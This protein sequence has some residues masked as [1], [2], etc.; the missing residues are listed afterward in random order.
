MKKLFIAITLMIYSFLS[1][2][3]LFAATFTQADLTGTW[4]I[5]NLRTSDGIK[6]MRAL[7]TLNSSGV[8][9]CVSLSDSGGGTTC[10]SPFDLTFTMN[11]TTGVITQSWTNPAGDDGHMTMTLNKIMQKVVP[12][13]TYSATD[14]QSKSM[15]YHQLMVGDS[16]SWEYGAATT[17]GLALVNI[18]S[19]TTPSGTTTPEDTGCTIEVDTMGVVT[20]TGLSCDMG[21]FSGFLSSDKKTIVG[22]RTELSADTYQLFIFQITGQT[23]TAGTFPAGTAVAHTL[24][25]GAAAFWI[26]YTNTIDSNGVM[27][28]SDWVASNPAITAPAETYTGYIDALGTVTINGNPTFHGQ[29][30][31]DRTFTVGTQ[32]G[33]VGN[34]LYML[35]VSTKVTPADTN[36]YGHFTGAGIWKWDGSTWSQV[37][38]NAPTEMA[39]SGSILYGNFSPGGIWKWD[40]STWSQVTP[41]SPTAMA[42]SG[43][44]LYGNFGT[45]AG[46]WKWDGSTWSQV[47]PNAPTAMAASGSLLY[48]NF[49]TGAGIWKWGGSTWS[50]VT[51]NSPQTMEAS[52]SLLYGNF[53]TGAGIWKWESS[54]WSQVTPNAPTAMAASGSLLYGN[55]GTG[56]GIWKWDGSSWSQVTPNNPISMVVGF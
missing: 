15:V 14:L 48:G 36:L 31:H 41:N 50:Q 20:L 52:G 25:C 9:T 32:T 40:G 11:E 7:V 21:T 8:A 54:T 43:S 42:A 37:T 23:Y 16:N 47:T 2:N 51:P 6:W 3:L 33:G 5:N 55:F 12:G 27:T 29:V 10:P 18:S 35:N 13:T 45:G 30:S 26:H 1:V 49:G 53:G 34:N 24:G 46:I 22:T 4:R 44:L 39:A 38:P 28:F 56:A 17:N 19:S